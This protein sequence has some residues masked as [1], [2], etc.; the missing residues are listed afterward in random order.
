[1]MKS[2]RSQT[3]LL[4]SSR[5]PYRLRQFQ[6]SS[7]GLEVASIEDDSSR[8]GRRR[9]PGDRYGMRHLAKSPETSR[10]IVAL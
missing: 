3:G 4:P 7:R 9:R 1:M 8:R 6:Q 5:S 10:H 2:R